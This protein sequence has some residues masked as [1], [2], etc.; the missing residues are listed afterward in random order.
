MAPTEIK[1]FHV[2]KVRLPESNGSHY[3]Y[4]R[5]HE[6]KP[7]QTPAAL[8]LS[9]RLMFLF[10]IPIET[11]FATLKK[12]FQQVAIGATM[13]GYIPSALTDSE[14]DAYVDLTKLTSDLEY[15]SDANVMEVA[16]KLPKLCGIVTFV[17]KA[18]LQLAFNSLK[19]L[20]GD[21]KSTNWP[22]QTLGTTFLRNKYREQ[23]YDTKEFS[24]SVAAALAD[25]NRAEQESKEELQKLTQIV[26]EDGF[27]L[28]VGSHRKTKAGILG[29]QKF[30]ATVESE[31]AAKKM[32]KKE[33]EDFYRFQ[34]REK[35]KAEMNDLLRKFKH[36]QERVRIMKEKKRFRPY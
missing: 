16:L 21:S 11:D 28:V 3:V 32:K 4:F 36:D 34:L 31:K 8:N 17:D 9:G 29:K 20:S 23:I 22:L 26:D 10:N 5:K 12:Y 30:A 7:G 25:F 24:D 13:E 18:A 15:L 2:L 6:V 27:T 35:K 33:K 1:G 14:E 19:K